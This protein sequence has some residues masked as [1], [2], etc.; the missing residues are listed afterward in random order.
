MQLEITRP[1]MLLD[2]KG[3]LVQKGYAKRPL[4]RYTKKFV[5]KK[6]R[7]KE[8]DYYLVYNK[9]YA[10]N[11]TVAKSLNLVFICVSIVDIKEKKIINKNTIRISPKKF[12]L[13]KDSARG[14]IIYKDKFIRLCV[15]IENSVRI[16]IL[17][18]YNLK[19]ETDLD[20]SLILFNEP[21]D[22]MVIA[23]PFDESSNNFIYNRKIFGM[24]ASGY[25]KYRNVNYG[26]SPA[27]SFAVINWVRGVLPYKT[28]WYWSSAAGKIH[29]KIFAFN[30]GC[31]LSDSSYA[32]ENMIIFDGTSSKLENVSFHIPKDKKNGYDYL[33]PWIIT[34][35]DS[36]I[37]MVFIP[38]ID[39]SLQFPLFP[40]PFSLNRHQVFGKFTGRAILDDW[41][42]IYLK[43]ILGFAQRTQNL[44]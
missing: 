17:K 28:T 8:W 2:N 5:K 25:V 38:I 33:K 27:D 12:K 26:F 11:L 31:G 10:L 21:N 16:L 40:F 1:S 42:V 34:S 13:P 19:K 37:D 30:L 6:H 7:L 18:K 29:G 43:E 39:R 32:T 36:R 44:W 22:S 3:K 35:S 41:P 20:I 24:R 14:S 4:L 23:A 9:N 15:K